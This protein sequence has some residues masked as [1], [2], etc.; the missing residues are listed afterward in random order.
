MP[1]ERVGGKESGKGKGEW[2][3][4]N[5]PPTFPA[6]WSLFSDPDPAP[7]PAPSLTQ[8]AAQLTHK[9]KQNKT[10]LARH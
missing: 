1:E 2:R 6:V 3:K 8:F 7:A 10:F 5:S 9:T 4:D